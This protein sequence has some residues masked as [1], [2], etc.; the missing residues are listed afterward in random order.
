[1]RSGGRSRCGRAGRGLL[2]NDEV[3]VLLVRP[4]V[5]SSGAPRR[6]RRQAVSAGLF[7][8]AVYLQRNAERLPSEFGAILLSSEL[9]A[10][11][12]RLWNESSATRR[13]TSEYRVGSRRPCS[14]RRSRGLRDGR[15]P[16]RASRPSA[17]LNAGRWDSSSRSSRVPGRPEFVLPDRVQVTMT[18]PFMRVHRAP[19]ADVPSRGAHAS[20]AWPRSSRPATGVF[21]RAC[22]RP[23]TRRAN[24]ATASTAPGLRTPDLVPVAKAEFDA[25]L[26]IGPP[27]RTL[28][29]GGDDRGVRPERRRHPGEITG[30]AYVP[31]SRSGFATSRRGSG[32]RR[33]GDRQ[34][35]GDAATAGSRAHRSGSGSTVASSARTSNGSSPR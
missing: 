17:G 31:T 12:A 19:R 2:V 32:C 25:V 6:G 28:A 7:D 18:V 11:E 10:A 5:A 35:H 33:R 30:R 27:A 13:I 26:G 34:P 20:G 8:F 1:M 22:P 23:R 16:S 4:R 15:D 21:E 9:R 14:S 3:A 24:R 29:R